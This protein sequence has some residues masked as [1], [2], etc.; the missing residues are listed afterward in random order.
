M[1]LLPLLKGYLS[2]FDRFMLIWYLVIFIA[3]AFGLVNTTLMAVLE[4]TREFGL[5][6]ALGLKPLRIVQKRAFGMPDPAAHRP[7]GRKCFL[8]Y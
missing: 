1:D 2:M 8:A 7:C 3:M 4:R 5:L 6:K